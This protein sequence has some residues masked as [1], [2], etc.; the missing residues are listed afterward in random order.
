MNFIEKVKKGQLGKNKGL[1]TGL[2][3]LNRAID[4][5]Q[6]RA[7]YGIAS[8]PKVGKTTFVDFCF[9]LEP[10]LYY[11]ELLRL[12]PDTT[13]KIH[14]IYFSFEIDRVKKE[15]KY[16]SYFMWKDY[17]IANFWHKNKLYEMSGRYLEGKL[18]DADD[19]VIL[20][21]PDHLEKLKLIY[22][23]RIIPLFGEYD[24]NGKK[25][26]DGIID[27]I[28]ER[29][30]PTGLRNYLFG[31]AEEHGHFT[32]ESYKTLEKGVM[33]TK[34]RIS[35]YKENDP[36]LVTIIITDHVRKLRREMHYN[37]KDNIDK[38]LEYQVELRNWCSFSFIDIV[39]LNRS[40]SNR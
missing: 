23:N 21:Q 9:V 20:L 27:F 19:E 24:I 16:A 2:D 4:G 13:T 39:H 15:L 1:S 26:R 3:N 5:I 8:A 25:I 14:W 22:Q 17:G 18:T 38:W 35:G 32:R 30:N 11:L 28:E 10:Y 29:D 12:H 7:I 33:V 6:K 34:Q 31:Y 36:D 37:M 40:L